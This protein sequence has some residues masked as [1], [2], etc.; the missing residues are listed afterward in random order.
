VGAAAFPTP[1]HIVALSGCCCVL[2][3]SS[4]GTTE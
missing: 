2:N 4:Y 3:V 1:D